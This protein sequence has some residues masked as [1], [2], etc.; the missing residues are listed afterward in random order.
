[1]IP[2]TI[3]TWQSKSWQEELAELVTD[4]AELLTLLELP[5]SLLPEARAA[6]S[7]FPLRVTRSFINRIQP[8][9]PADPLLLQVL[10]LGIELDPADG[11][12]SDPLE[13]EQ[14]NPVPGIVH[15]YHG[16]LLLIAA[17]QCAIN[18]RYCFRRHFDYQSNSL[19]RSQWQ[20]ALAYIAADDSLSEVILS[21]G[22]PLVVG[23]R[24]LAWLIGELERIPH[25]RRL[26]IHSRLPIVLPSRITDALVNT[27]TTSRLQIITVV[28]CNHANEID[29]H[30]QM[31]LRRLK[32]ASDALLNQAVLL[33][34]INDT[35]DSLR[36]L[37]ERLF[38]N[39]VL[40]YYLHL[41]DKVSGAAHFQVEHSV[42]LALHKQLQATS[43]GYLVPKLVRED[44]GALNKTLIT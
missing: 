42:A 38:E 16:R 4:P 8:A 43:P 35:A 25:V 39:G 10:P 13:E 44:A 21:G 7:A 28:H 36:A 3:P 41:L 6:A 40:P 22:D 19:S 11:F 2:H 5:H 27:L 20:Q 37:N 23:D 24:Q 18:C 15:K 14:S 34:T 9:N 12:S 30:V 17:S 1:M 29:I 33:K 26:R 31:A 32:S